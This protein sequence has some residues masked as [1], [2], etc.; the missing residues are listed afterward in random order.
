MV[1]LW[2]CHFTYTFNCATGHTQ[3]IRSMGWCMSA[4]F[5]FLFLFCCSQNESLLS[6]ILSFFLSLSTW[7]TFL[8][9]LHGPI[10]H[11][12][13]KQPIEIISFN[14]L[15]FRWSAL[16]YLIS[17]G[18]VVALLVFLFSAPMQ[19]KGQ[20]P[21]TKKKGKSKNE[22][23]TVKLLCR[24]FPSCWRCVFKKEVT[25][26]VYNCGQVI[27]MKARGKIGPHTGRQ[28]LIS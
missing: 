9:N 3:R 5:P 12:I 16:V 18:T 19:H 22:W 15:I 4:L 14:F 25:L 8:P 17:D 10:S 13:S 27:S 20:Q 21:E 11:V 28:Q 7:T 26:N 24:C 2:P 6:F 1:T 23:R